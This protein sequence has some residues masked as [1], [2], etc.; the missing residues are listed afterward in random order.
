MSA[1]FNLSTIAAR[2]GTCAALMFGLSASPMPVVQGDAG[3]DPALLP[4]VPA[5]ELGLS[6]DD[7]LVPVQPER[8]IPAFLLESPFSKTDRPALDRIARA[9]RDF[10]A[11]RNAG[12]EA[13]IAFD[14]A[15][16]TD[17]RGLIAAEVAEARQTLAPQPTEAGASGMAA[18]PAGAYRVG[19]DGTCAYETIQLAVTAAPNGATVRVSE[20]AFSQSIDITGT[21]TITIAG[22]YD[23]TCAN[24]VAGAT[25]SITATSGSAIDVNASGVYLMNLR[26]AGGV[27]FG[28]GVD[29]YGTN[30]WA[31]L[32]NTILSG[33]NGTQGGGIYI[34]YG[35]AAT[36]TNGSTVRLNTA[37]LYGGGVAVYGR[38][39][40]IDTYSDIS[41]NDASIDGGGIYAAT[42][43][44]YLNGSDVIANR[45][46]GATGRGGGIYADSAVITLTSGAYVGSSGQC[47]NRAH[48]GAGIY[49]HGSRITTLGSNVVIMNNRASGDGGGMY[50]AGGSVLD[51]VSNTNIGQQSSPTYGNTATLGAGMFMTNSSASFAG[52]VY[53]NTAS[54]NGGGLYAHN[55]V[56]SLPGAV[57]EGN[58]AKNN[59]GGLY[60]AGASALS[61]DGATV[62]TALDGNTAMTGSGGG[63]YLDRSGL[64]ARNCAFS[65]NYAAANG[66]ALAADAATLSIGGS[67]P[68]DTTLPAV[69]GVPVFYNNSAVFS[70]SL[71]TQG[72]GGAIY[73]NDT[74]LSL[75]RA[76]LHGNKATRGGAILQ[77]GSKAIGWITNTLIYSNTTSASYGAGIRNTEGALTV[78]HSTIA[79]NVGGGGVS[80]LSAVAQSYVYNNI[81][82]GNG[83]SS[84]GDPVIAVCSID[85]SGRYGTNTN[86]RFVSPGAGEDYTLQLASPAID[87][88]PGAGVSADLDGRA[89]PFGPR[90]DM[91]AYEMAVTRV[92]VPV[93]L[94]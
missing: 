38:L 49:A 78:T 48:D 36:L 12:P 54:E 47:C 63:V 30:A 79:N 71:S 39:N 24:F 14:V 34:S 74:W 46:L 27:G 65:N 58:L 53:A 26:V 5:P 72:L 1:P 75:D 16:E 44:A 3:P 73:A 19:V 23:A 94:R 37:A 92:F 2:L 64:A 40:A 29:V 59:G 80:T 88:C 25:S 41:E 45:A 68:T 22:G 10:D 61:C 70:A 13:V 93:A 81:V 66:G 6:G 11:A 50:L 76:I 57:F 83:T 77:E 55:S 15:A 9:M 28:A 21:K 42:G 33:N 31:T 18:V 85:Q 86:P 17:V 52:K 90:F 69:T 8:P 43:T 84:G 67:A 91:G 35:T 89:R 51:A 4:M 87:A 56:I 62:G 7:G 32:S 20:G 60:A 82:Y